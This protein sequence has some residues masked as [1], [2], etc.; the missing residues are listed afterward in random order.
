[1]N[2][3]GNA[4]NNNASNTNGAAPDFVIIKERIKYCQK[5]N[6]LYNKAQSK[7]IIYNFWFVNPSPRFLWGKNKVPMSKHKRGDSSGLMPNRSTIIIKQIIKR[8]FLWRNKI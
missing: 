7:K 1:M 3:S 8:V 5:I 4:N 2:T 6:I